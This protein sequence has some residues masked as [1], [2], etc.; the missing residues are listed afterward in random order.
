MTAVRA[1]EEA[2]SG[3]RINKVFGKI[4]FLQKLLDNADLYKYNI[5]ADKEPIGQYN[6]KPVYP[7]FSWLR[8]GNQGTYEIDDK[9]SIN[10]VEPRAGSDLFGGALSVLSGGLS[11]AVS[12]KSP[13]T[14]ALESVNAPDWAQS[15]NR[16]VQGI[17]NPASRGGN[18]LH[19]WASGDTGGWEALDQMVDLP[20]LSTSETNP[21]QGVVDKGFRKLGDYQPQWFK[22]TMSTVGPAIGAYFYGPGGAAAMSGMASKAQQG[23][24]EDTA[25]YHS[26]FRNAGISALAAWL[27]GEIKGAAAPEEVPVDYSP[28]LETP[29]P[30]PEFHYP[31]M[32]ETY[33]PSNPLQDIMNQYPADIQMPPSSG[34]GYDTGG[35]PV[36]G[37][38]VETPSGSGGGSPTATERIINTLSKPVMKL[39]AEK[40][41]PLNNGYANEASSYSGPEPSYSSSLDPEIGGLTDRQRLLLQ[42]EQPIRAQMARGSAD[43]GINPRT[44]SYSGYVKKLGGI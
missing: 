1:R 2:A 28:E 41:Y 3:E 35:V 38:P 37:V 44:K 32:P 34:G 22:D 19:S 25:D 40:A 18:I 9:G 43:L 6:D 24:D 42:L 17:I 36:P 13:F 23:S 14:G 29:T 30:E 7:E 27:A 4:P 10:Y 12:G 21:N 31:G 15:G 26:G 20:T 16:F 33:N 39:A 8:G 11:D 5:F